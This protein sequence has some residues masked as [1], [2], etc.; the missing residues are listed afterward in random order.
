MVDYIDCKDCTGTIKQVAK[1]KYRPTFYAT[2]FCRVLNLHNS[3]SSLEGYEDNNNRSIRYNPNNEK[4]MAM[5]WGI[6]IED[7]ILN[8]MLGYPFNFKQRP[9]TR[10]FIMDSNQ[11]FI[12]GL[13]DAVL[14][15]KDQFQDKHQVLLEIK[16]PYNGRVPIKPSINWFV[17]CQ[18]EMAS[19]NGDFK[20]M[21][22]ICYTPTCMSCWM[23]TYIPSFYHKF[24]RTHLSDLCNKITTCN[25][26]A[27]KVPFSNFQER[28][29]FMNECTKQIHQNTEMLFCLRETRGEE[30]MYQVNHRYKFL[31]RNLEID[32]ESWDNFKTILDL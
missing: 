12:S 26:D 4:E 13:P 15:Y 8:F 5:F 2:N 31:F 24:L 9:L 18:I 11:F 23:I 14:E 19:Y 3:P 17:Q 20:E 6:M 29:E 1:S 30:I 10:K 7:R 22:L 32:Q 21:L 16:A 27:L 28:N 25:F